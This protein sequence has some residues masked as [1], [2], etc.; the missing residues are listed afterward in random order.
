MSNKG[1]I[2]AAVGVLAVVAVGVFL[3]LNRPQE[4]GKVRVAGNLPLTGPVA[5]WSGQYGKAFT[6]GIDDGCADLGVPRNTFALDFQDNAGK[7]ADAVSVFQKQQI[8]G[9]DVYI[10]GSSEMT[11][12]VA[13]QVDT[14]KVPHFIVAFDAFLT[15]ENPARLRI[16]PN[17]KIEGPL[18]IRYAKM[19]KAK[20]VYII[21]LNSFYANNEFEKIVEPGLKEAGIESQ[22][23]LFDF[24]QKDYKTIALK[25]KEKNPDL[26]F[27]C[28]YSF[29][30]RP[31]VRDLRTTGLVKDGSVMSVLDFVD[32][33]YD[34]TPKEE[35]EGV[36][37]A[38]PLIEIKDR[39]PAAK[40]WRETYKKK[41]GES[42]TYVAAY[43]YDSG[44]VLAKAQKESGKTDKA[45]ILKA[46][47]YEGVTGTIRL[48]EGGDII[49][50]VTLARVTS[51][52]TVEELPNQK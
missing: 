41:F 8:N 11:Q 38:S 47:P 43:A 18:F 5:A 3:F 23:E 46:L 9:F 50:T 20:N 37:F 27:V 16:M 2:L 17:C 1:R 39:V 10:S 26:I 31:L 45:S 36:V 29:H 30:L 49:A 52:G 28:G 24:N 21:N 35:L 19:R 6:M 44:R 34:N 12:A 32:M 25:V 51:D 4:T 14:T 7:P 15:V 42:P 33:L 40:A 48:D 13:K 22:R